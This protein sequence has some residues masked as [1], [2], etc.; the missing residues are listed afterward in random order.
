[1][2]LLLPFAP[3]RP[4]LSAGEQFGHRDRPSRRLL[5]RLERE[6]VARASCASP[7][8]P[9]SLPGG[10]LRHGFRQGKAEPFSDRFPVKVRGVA[11][12]PDRRLK[13]IFLV[14]SRPTDRRRVTSG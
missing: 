13:R 1:M 10:D 11:V 4:L 12:S 2:R 8:F 14:L 6:P 7:R 3:G 5:G 9:V